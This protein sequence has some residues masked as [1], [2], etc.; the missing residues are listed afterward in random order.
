M[1]AKALRAKAQR[2][3]DVSRVLEDVREQLH[4]WAEDYDAEAVAMD[5]ATRHRRPAAPTT[6]R[7]AFKRPGRAA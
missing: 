4:V 7:G 6:R 3:R 2:C 1:D 5:R